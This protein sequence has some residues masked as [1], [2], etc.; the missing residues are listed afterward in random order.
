MRFKCHFFKR[1]SL[2]FF[3][4]TFCIV[5]QAQS[6]EL[7]DAY[8]Q[9]VNTLK[10]YKFQSEDV[11]DSHMEEYAKTKSITVKLQGGYFIFTFNDSFG[12]FSDPF[13]GFRHG[14]KTIK[15]AIAEVEFEAGRYDSYLTI[16]GKDGIDFSFKNQKEI[17]REY[18][19]RGAELS[20]KKLLNELKELQNIAQVEEFKGTLGGGSTSK[21]SS[22]KKNNS[23]KKSK[24]S[25]SKKATSKSSKSK[26][27]GKYVE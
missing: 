23:S 21:G 12:T 19:I 24:G 11:Y 10:Q 27:V 6:Q 14:I 4:L 22:G 16:S 15:V 13:F 18:R 7:R 3:M 1:V 2:L 25:T 17:L 8:N 20:I 26:K 5:C 9:V